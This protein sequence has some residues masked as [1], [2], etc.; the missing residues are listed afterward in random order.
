MAWMRRQPKAR[1]TK[2]KSRIDDFADI[3]HRAHQRRNDHEVQ[4]ELNMERLG[5]SIQSI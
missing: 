5:S 3:K 4:L 2:S 1:T